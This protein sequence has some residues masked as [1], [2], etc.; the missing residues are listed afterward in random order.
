MLT[1]V[2]RPDLVLDPF[3]EFSPLEISRDELDRLFLSDVS[4]YL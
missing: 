3:G 1:L 2:A 4:G